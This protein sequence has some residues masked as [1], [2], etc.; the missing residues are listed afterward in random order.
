MLKILSLLLGGGR[1]KSPFREVTESIRELIKG[2]EVDPKTALEYVQ[3]LNIA[4]AK[5]RSL[6]V[7]GW[8]P[9][10]G[11]VGAMILF[12]NYIVAPIITWALPESNPPQ[13]DLD[14]LWPVITG[15][16]GIAGMRSYDKTK[17]QLNNNNNG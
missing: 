9:A 14:A 13:L 5:H 7:A 3:Q 11:W 12:F 10:I 2:K 4:E 8:R 17:Q 6:F 15:M 1:D 16:L